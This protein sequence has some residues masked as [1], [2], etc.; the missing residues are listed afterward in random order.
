MAVTVGAHCFEALAGLKR[1][2]DGK[3]LAGRILKFDSSAATRDLLAEA[4]KRAGN[5]EL[6]GYVK[7]L[8]VK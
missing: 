7:P 3:N 1:N 6:A 8:S 2:R 4:A 5:S